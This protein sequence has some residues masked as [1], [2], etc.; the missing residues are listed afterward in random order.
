MKNFMKTLI[1]AGLLCHSQSA[2][3]AGFLLSEQSVSAM[4]TAFAANTAGVEDAGT[5]YLN[6]AG[7]TSML[8]PNDFVSGITWILPNSKYRDNG[9]INA[10]G[11]PMG[12]TVCQPNTNGG[13][14]GKDAWLPYMA[15]VKKFGC[16]WAA[17]ITI[18]APFGLAT[19]YNDAWY[20]RY[21]ATYSQVLTTNINPA[22]AYDITDCLTVGAG[23]SAQYVHV[24]NK[25]MVDFGLIGAGL[26][27][28]GLAP[29]QNDGKVTLKGCAWGVGGNVGVLY[30]FNCDR[31]R[32]GVQ[33]RSQIHYKINNGHV[34]YHN[35]PAALGTTFTNGG[36]R[37]KV[38]LPDVVSA[39]VMHRWNNCLTVYG[40]VQWTNWSTL[41]SLNIKFKNPAPSLQESTT[42]FKW[43]NAWHF[44]VGLKYDIT[45]ELAVRLGYMYDQAPT[46][47]SYYIS[48]RVP[49]ADRQWAA[50]GLQYW[51]TP[52]ISVDLGYA[53]LFVD[54]SYANKTSGITELPQDPEVRTAGGLKGRWR[55]FVDLIGFQVHGSF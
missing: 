38:T 29:E 34:R 45:C 50:F 25:N 31:T 7:M 16:R 9:T 28:P 1:L 12:S 4:G 46:R 35:V 36:A 14:I 37:A 13:Q 48:P 33:Y 44:A 43:K 6:P 49:D 51:A 19:D 32:I 2:E 11:Q 17:G 22:I 53:H 23:I 42:T 20:G 40:D 5:V 47:S 27:I 39:G 10:L 24:V 52:C 26:G 18:N 54:R 55:S 21:Y 15:F 3:A 41:Q 30:K 8:R